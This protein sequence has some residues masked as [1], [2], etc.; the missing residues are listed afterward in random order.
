MPEVDLPV[1]ENV[2]TPDDYLEAA[3]IAVTDGKI[4]SMGNSHKPAAV[5][6][7]DASGRVILAGVSDGRTPQGA[8]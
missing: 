7:Y 8:L 3:W 2:V 4:V 1:S 5:Y 6:S